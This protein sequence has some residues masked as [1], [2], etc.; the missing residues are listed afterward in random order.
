VNFK[1]FVID[2]LVFGILHEDALGGLVG[3]ILWKNFLCKVIFF[4][5]KFPFSKYKRK[6]GG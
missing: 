2:R 3:E 4:P 6:N 1:L 5:P